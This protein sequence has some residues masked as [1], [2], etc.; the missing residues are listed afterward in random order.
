MESVADATDK[1]IREECYPGKPISVF[2][3]SP[4]KVIEMSCQCL[5]VGVPSFARPTPSVFITYY[6]HTYIHEEEVLVDNLVVMK[7]ISKPPNF[8]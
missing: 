8:L 1:K 5:S 2:S 7:R 4:H 3:S 6:R